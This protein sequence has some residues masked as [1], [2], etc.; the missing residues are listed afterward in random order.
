[1]ND[2]DI[3]TIAKQVAQR[4]T[5]EGIP[6]NP[7]GAE[8]RSVDRLLF[9]AYMAEAGSQAVA[10]PGETVDSNLWAAQL[11]MAGAGPAPALMSVWALV[12]VREGRQRVL[13]VHAGEMHPW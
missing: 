7:H 3:T 8:L 11:R 1:M 10:C 4:L 12:L 13:D 6:N 9:Q 2:L 5:A